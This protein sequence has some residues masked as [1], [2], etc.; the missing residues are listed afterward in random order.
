MIIGG[1]GLFAL[2]IYRGL[3]NHNADPIVVFLALVITQIGVFGLLVPRYFI[4]YRIENPIRER[5]DIAVNIVIWLSSLIG[6]L[7]L[8]GLFR[9]TIFMR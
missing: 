5:Y 2:T 4:K 8:F 7:V 1:S 3:S 6:T 9:G